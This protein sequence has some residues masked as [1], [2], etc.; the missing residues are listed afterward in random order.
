VLIGTQLAATTD[1]AGRFVIPNTDPGVYSLMYRLSGYGMQTRTDVQ[2]VGGVTTSVD[3]N[4][5]PMS[6]GVVTFSVTAGRSGAQTAIYSSG[7]NVALCPMLAFLAAWR[8]GRVQ[9]YPHATSCVR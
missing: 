2:S 3:A 5:S 8:D 7:S 6:P 9:A 4:L 1:S